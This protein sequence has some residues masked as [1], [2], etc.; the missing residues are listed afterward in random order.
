MSLFPGQPE[1]A[2]KLHAPLP[3]YQPHTGSSG[4][5]GLVLR[6]S[7]S[8][9]VHR[10]MKAEDPA[11]NAASTERGSRLMREA[12]RGGG[13]A[14]LT[15]SR[16]E[17]PHIRD[18]EHHGFI[19]LHAEPAHHAYEFRAELTSKGRAHMQ[20]QTRAETKDAKERQS[21]LFKGDFEGLIQQLRGA[22]VRLLMKAA[23]MKAHSPPR[24]GLELEASK[25]N[26]RVHRWV[27]VTPDSKWVSFK[28]PETGA[29][30]V[31]MVTGGSHEGIT[32]VDHETGLEHAIKHGEY[33]NTDTPEKIKAGQPMIQRA[34]E[35][36]GG[37]PPV[38][39]REKHPGL[40]KYPPQGAREV[41][42]AKGGE[43]WTLRW[44][45]PQH[46]KVQYGYPSSYLRDNSKQKFERMASVGARLGDFREAMQ[47]HMKTGGSSALPVVAAMARVVD[48]TAARPG[49]EESATM[50]VHGIS[51]ML[52]KHVSN[53]TDQG[54]TLSYIGKDKIP[55]EH[56]IHDPQVA[57]V[58]KHLM[59]LPG[60]RLFQY[61][62]PRGKLV[63]ATA[64]HLNKYVD[65]HLGSAHTV[66]DLRTFH[67]TRI[68][69]EAVDRL[70]ASSNPD[71]T[72]RR[73]RLAAHEV[74]Q[75]LGHKRAV[76]REWVQT[77]GEV[78]DQ[79][80]K[81]AGGLHAGDGRVGFRTK[82]EA[83]AF[84]AAHEGAKTAKAPEGHVEHEHEGQTALDNYIDPT[85]IA[86]YRA[87]HTLSGAL[88][89]GGAPQ[90][91][92][93]MLS[94]G[95]HTFLDLMDRVKGADPLGYYRAQKLAEAEKASEDGS[96]DEDTEESEGA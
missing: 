60:D 18:L 17:H 5:E 90:L 54:V 67:A 3:P 4:H 25:K 53:L 56:V 77:S 45:H 68:F 84:R 55:Q 72:E 9:S 61:H 43:S 57:A 41:T 28:H 22:K 59:T 38:D 79:K 37:S 20:A 52:K 6:V 2:T 21:G 94:H 70:G 95:E 35:E 74:A 69:A 75:Q 10:W 81:A 47:Q 36:S 66:K 15:R 40:A 16:A 23:S 80:V 87:G 89:K 86:A 64:D 82:K 32:A 34:P 76:S 39:W 12:H 73:I 42:E 49:N 96:E 13:L 14:Y 51:T 58:V 92:H 26:P 83:E 19:Q 31:G 93:P 7:K 11:K 30:R 62:D 63:K 85:I 50:G 1:V 78:D 65:A 88:K 8:G 44:K 33:T 29:T 46:D 91:P 48:H 71:E 24:A 27:K